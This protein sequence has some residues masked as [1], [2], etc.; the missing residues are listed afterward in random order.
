MSLIFPSPSPLETGEAQQRDLFPSLPFQKRLCRSRRRDYRVLDPCIFFCLI[1]LSCSKA[2]AES[3]A[4]RRIVTILP[5]PS[6]LPPVLIYRLIMQ[7]FVGCSFIPGHIWKT[8]SKNGLAR[9]KVVKSALGPGNMPGASTLRMYAR[10]NSLPTVSSLPSPRRFEMSPGGLS[11]H[12]PPDPT[13]YHRGFTRRV[14]FS[15]LLRHPIPPT[16]PAD[17]P[18]S[19][20]ATLI[21]RV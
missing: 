21:K 17:K 2:H 9:E 16:L 13:R 5:L 11:H 10:G 20:H 7:F 18:A 4:H 1:A 12:H 6:F 19:D 8:S 14:S 3:A 15:C